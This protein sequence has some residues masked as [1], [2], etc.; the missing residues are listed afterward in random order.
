MIQQRPVIILSEMGSNRLLLHPDT[1]LKSSC[2]FADLPGAIAFKRGNVRFVPE[3]DII[4]VRCILRETGHPRLH[5]AKL[6]PVFRPEQ[7]AF[8]YSWLVCLVQDI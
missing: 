3:A 4:Y 2:R 1:R 7:N 5:L 8:R 6:F